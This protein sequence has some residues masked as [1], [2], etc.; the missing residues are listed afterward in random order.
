MKIKALFF[1]A[2]LSIG[3]LFGF[4]CN[5]S[6]KELDNSQHTIEQA[7]AASVELNKQFNLLYNN[8][9]KLAIDGNEYAIAIFQSIGPLT[10]NIMMISKSLGLDC[11]K[12]NESGKPIMIKDEETGELNP[13]EIL[14]ET[15]FLEHN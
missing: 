6:N 12:Y 9:G 3:F 7:R 4:F 11:R 15:I 14:P 2:G 10:H 8:S 5:T 13:I 1:V